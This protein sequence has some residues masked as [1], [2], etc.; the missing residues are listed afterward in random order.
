[1]KTAMLFAVLMTAMLTVSISYAMWQKALAINGTVNTGYMDGKWVLALNF[2]PP[3][4][5]VSLDPNPDGTRKDQD[6]GSTT[7]SGIGTDTLV[8]TVN[9]AYPSYFNDIE[10]EY[11]YTGT[12]PAEVQSIEIIPNGFTLATAYGANDGPIWV[13]FVDGIGTKLHQG[14]EQA[15]SFKIHVEQCAQQGTSYTFTVKLRLVQWNE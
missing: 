2:D 8:V 11:R 5:P 4:P 13:K 12:I 6:V 7:V 14:D 9:N 10:V 3:A 1:M 15:S